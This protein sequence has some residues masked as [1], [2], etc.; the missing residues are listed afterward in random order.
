MGVFLLFSL[1][2]IPITFLL[3]V[4]KSFLICTCLPILDILLFLMTAILTNRWMIYLTVHLICLLLIIGKIISSIF[5]DNCCH[6]CNSM[7]KKS[8]FIS[9]PYFISCPLIFKI[10][11]LSFL[12]LDEFFTLNT[13]FSGT[14]LQFFFALCTCYI[15]ILLMMSL[16]IVWWCT[17]VFVFTIFFDFGV[18][19]KTNNLKTTNYP[20][21][22]YLCFLLRIVMI[23]ALKFK[24]H[25]FENFVD[26]PFY[27][28]VFGMEGK[29]GWWN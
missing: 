11:L 21:I 29:Y 6:L 7:G 19:S 14:R 8:L 5:S 23:S 22:C 17:F 12:T 28:V 9:C 18:K 24:F 1:V 3:T 25:S 26:S 16:S 2:T 13:D 4:Y 20:G 27:F 10:K 15:Y